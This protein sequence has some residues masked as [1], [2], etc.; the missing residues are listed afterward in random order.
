MSSYA[1]VLLAV[2]LLVVLGV[3]Q[4]LDYKL[5]TL[6]LSAPTEDPQLGDAADSVSYFR[7]LLILDA[8]TFSILAFFQP[9][10][11]DI[12]CEENDVVPSTCLAVQNGNKCSCKILDNRWVM[13]LSNCINPYEGSQIKVH[14]GAPTD[15]SARQIVSATIFL[16]PEPPPLDVQFLQ[17]QTPLNQTSEVVH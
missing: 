5:S 4:N 1:L 16:T 7:V 12:E 8:V 17:L 14:A 13:V 6:P 10:T 2:S 15:K 11:W 3:G 9:L